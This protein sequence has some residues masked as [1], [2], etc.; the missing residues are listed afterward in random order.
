MVLTVRV[1]RAAGGLAK[2]FSPDGNRARGISFSWT[3]VIPPSRGLSFLR[4]FPDPRGVRVPRLR[5][6]DRL[7]DRVR[8]SGG[9]GGGV[10]GGG[11]GG[12][13]GPPRAESQGAGRRPRWTRPCRAF[14]SL[15][16]R[17]CESP[18]GDPRWCCFSSGCGGGRSPA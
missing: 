17:S 9:T 16:C 13:R 7:Q 12:G 4:G 18:R 8:A 2:R 10:D 14:S 3:S 1:D 15:S 5:E 6:R 11:A